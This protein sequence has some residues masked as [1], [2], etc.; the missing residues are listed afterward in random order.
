MSIARLSVNPIVV[1]RRG[2]AL[3]RAASRLRQTDVA[4]G[5]DPARIMLVGLCA[6]GI[7]VRVA[8]IL[9]VHALTYPDSGNYLESTVAGLWSDPLRTAGYPMFLRVLRAIT[10]HLLLVIVLQHV[11]GV[12]A[13][14]LL[15]A[16][17]R[18]LG[19]PTGLALVPCAAVL[20]SGDEL[21]IEH[22]L[23]SEAVFTPLLIATLYCAVRAR[24]SGV[25]WAAVAG[26][27]AGL[28]V[29]TRV[30]ALPLLVTGPVWLVLCERRPTPRTLAL[31]AVS[32]IVGLATV[33][34]YTEWHYL[35]S[36]QGGLV[37]GDGWDLYGR[38]APFADC[39][40][41]TPPA[42]TESLC[43]AQPPAQRPPAQT[44][45][46]YVFNRSSP[47]VRSIGPAEDTPEPGDM[48]RLQ[49]FS[50]AA[51]E[52][53]PLDYLH[54]VSQDAIRLIDPSH[55]SSNSLTASV[56]MTALFTRR[57]PTGSIAYW[58]RRAYP[59]DPLKHGRAGP[60]RSWEKLTRITGVPF[61]V[62]LVLSLLA[63][64]SVRGDARSETRLIVGTTLV[65][66]LFPLF[67]RGYEYRFVIPLL[68][69]F[70]VGASLG[71]WGLL[72]RLRRLSAASQSSRGRARTW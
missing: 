9:S 43:E 18:R 46:W 67:V 6:A 52:G 65:L 63:P 57:K 45:V 17:M 11:M 24:R 1:D 64:W 27:C 35:E 10:P 29:W 22:A 34:V 72:Q 14:L 49:R 37:T 71:G 47:A 2:S 61:V 32:L 58:Q 54:D 53:Q 70:V 21:L 23:L 12:A 50:L 3:R 48:A 31:G 26:V 38:V 16:I 62:L 56:L 33:A 8:L 4:L 44:G 55:A 69:P 7:L 20:L 15:F 19:A 40:Q 30:A 28:S 68:G 59:G 41:F 36:G 13:A 25:A 42:G 66:L 39:R 51:I 60:F 5:R